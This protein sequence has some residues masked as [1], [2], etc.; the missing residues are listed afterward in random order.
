MQPRHARQVTLK[1]GMDLNRRS[2]RSQSEEVAVENQ[3]TAWVS[4]CN[5]FHWVKMTFFAVFAAFCKKSIFLFRVTA[6]TSPVDALAQA[7]GDPSGQG[8]SGS[9]APG[10]NL[11]PNDTGCKKNNSWHPANSGLIQTRRLAA[12]PNPARLCHSLPTQTTP[13]SPVHGLPAPGSKHSIPSTKS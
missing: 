5:G 13:K 1:T 8:K 6:P 9:F 2:Q 11:S 7:P 3:L 4:R 10:A 12:S